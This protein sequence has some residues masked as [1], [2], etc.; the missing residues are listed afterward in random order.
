MM[1]GSTVSNQRQ[2]TSVNDVFRNLLLKL[3]RE[4]EAESLLYVT[5]G[6]RRLATDRISAT[7]VADMEER[8]IPQAVALPITRVSLGPISQRR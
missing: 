8:R 4:E 3:L 2:K 7:L 5:A 1:A 6:G